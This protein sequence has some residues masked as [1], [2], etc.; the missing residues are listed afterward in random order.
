M[1]LQDCRNLCAK[2]LNLDKL[3]ENIQYIADKYPTIVL[4]LNAI[5]GFPTETE[6]EA[7]GTI[8][9]IEDIK[10]LHFVQ[11]HNLR[12]FPGSLAETIA[13]SNWCYQTTNRGIPYNAI[14]I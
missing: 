6:E 4:G 5:H 13:L 7:I 11:L 10:W 14:T 9:F 12:I 1:L 2:I 3:K 8:Q